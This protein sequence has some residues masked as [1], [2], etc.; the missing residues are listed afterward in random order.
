MI[1]G[2]RSPGHMPVAASLLSVVIDPRSRVRRG[3]IQSD[4]MNAIS[5]VCHR[6]R[7]SF[8][9]SAASFSIPAMRWKTSTASNHQAGQ[10]PEWGPNSAAPVASFTRFWEHSNW[11][12][13]MLRGVMSET[14]HSA[15]EISSSRKVTSPQWYSAN[16]QSRRGS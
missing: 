9:R 14:G 13:H 5:R 11:T 15:A 3:A 8:S 6:R 10:R 1:S 16:H 4:A 12:S 7:L 2:T